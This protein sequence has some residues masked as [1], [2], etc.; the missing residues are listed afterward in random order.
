LSGAIAA[1][2]VSDW[3]VRNSHYADALRA[4]VLA[5]TVGAAI[6]GIAVIV[7]AHGTQTSSPQELAIARESLVA[8]YSGRYNAGGPYPGPSTWLPAPSV[9]IVDELPVERPPLGGRGQRNPALIAQYGLWAYG[10]YL[11][12]SA[13]ASRAV[14]LNTANWLVS[15]QQR[16]GRWIYH[17]VDNYPGGNLEPPWA[18][19]L[20]QGQAMSLLERA[21]RLTNSRRY[22]AAA[23][24]A[25]QP[26]ERPVG[27]GGLRRCFRNDCRLLFFEE[28]PTREPSFILNGFMF[29]LVGLYDL[30]TVAPSSNAQTL[31]L[32]GRRTLH[33]ALPAYDHGGLASYDLLTGRIADAT[34]QAIHVYL[35]RALNSLR[36]DHRFSVYAQRW[37]RHLSEAPG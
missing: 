11:A 7:F 19:A 22:L 29:T 12:R 37:R 8:S 10:R 1:S 31:Y 35:L 4:A 27:A 13:R 26:L 25:L 16:D 34:Y 33:A 15:K 30:S 21:Y 9:R 18:S 36:G 24:R 28:A 20:A 32:A 3:C 14:V 5:I 6:A 2:D 23:I 17:F